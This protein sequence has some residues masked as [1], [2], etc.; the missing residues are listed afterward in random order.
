M[1]KQI[2]L[3]IIFLTSLSVYAQPQFS[4]IA[5]RVGAF[6]RLGFGARGIGMGNSMT[7]VTKGELVSYYNPALSA[8][9]ENN[10]FQ[11]S[12]T[13]LS[14]DRSLNFISFTRNFKMYGKPDSSGNRKLRSTAGISLGLIN[15]GVSNI[16][17]R[18]N[19]GIKTGDLSTTENQFFISVSNRFSSKF[20]LGLAVKFYH[21]SLF[22]NVSSSAL[23]IDLGFLYSINDQWNVAFVIS[24]INSK[25]KFDTTPVLEQDGSNSENKFP[26]LKKIAVAYRNET[27]GILGS[28]EL[29]ISNAD[30]KIIKAGAEYKVIED[31]FVRAGLDQLNLNNSDFLPKPS[32]GFSYYKLLGDIKLG[33]SYAFMIEQYSSSDRHVI[34]VNINF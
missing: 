26:L 3:S 21:Y 2:L 1:K 8:F 16:D 19:Q 10:S 30:T 23:G 34:G 7:A 33:V 24:D 17:K 4:G 29:E 28:L 6:S 27:I 14:L 25:Y 9:Q 5:S 12:Y 31:F 11:S 18:D 32:A 15:A 13:F 22:D 20:A